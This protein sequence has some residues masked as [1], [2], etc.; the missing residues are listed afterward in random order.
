[1]FLPFTEPSPVFGG[2]FIHAQVALHAF[3][4]FWPLYGF[5]LDRAATSV[6]KTHRSLDQAVDD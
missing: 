3:F 4:K 2:I 5:G 1:L 6:A